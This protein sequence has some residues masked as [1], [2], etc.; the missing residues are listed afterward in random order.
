MSGLR[1]VDLSKV[2]AGPLCGQFLGALGAD[3][4]KV[5]PIGGGDDTRAWPP[6]HGNQSATFLAVNHNKR[7]LT[8][9]LK[10]P[11][12][13]RLVHRLVAGADIVIQGFGAG[14]AAKLAVDHD[15]LR[16]LNPRLIYV[17]ISG[18]GRT[19]PLGDEPG[20]DVMLQ[21]FSGMISTMGE[22]EGRYARAP[23]S[24]VDL[25][26]GSYALSGVLAAVIERERTGTGS[27][28]EVS[29]LDTAISQMGYLAQNYWASGEAPRRMGTGHPALCPY[30]AFETSDG[31]L[32]VGVGNDAQWRRLC[33]AASLDDL[34]EDPRFATT[35]SRVAHREVTVR[36]VADVIRRRTTEAWLTLLRSSGVPCSPINTLAQALGHPQVDARE[37]LVRYADPVLGPVQTVGLPV[38]FDGQ[39][40]DI[41]RPA[42]LLGQHTEDVLGELGLSPEEVRSLVERGVV[43]Q[44]VDVEDGLAPA[45]RDARGVE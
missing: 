22:P 42:P 14:T 10:S 30:Q 31:D 19:G 36:L 5:E 9:D 2:L 4:L 7:S 28:V 23:F 17:E 38:K 41:T 45:A 16:E 8:V 13:Q 26:T 34:L 11:E 15:T 35:A 18:Y 20:Y 33:A 12:G 6:R 25:G 21:A 43:A 3:V 24:P 29:L 27:Y 39:P 1:V 44:G 40:R 37:L 32:M